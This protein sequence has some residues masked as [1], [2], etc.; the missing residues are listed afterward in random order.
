MPQVTKNKDGSLKFTDTR[1][2]EK[3]LLED[4]DKEFSSEHMIFS[5]RTAART[6]EGALSTDAKSKPK[7]SAES[8]QILDRANHLKQFRS[9]MQLRIDDGDSF[10]DLVKDLASD[11]I[12]RG[13]YEEIAE[14][15]AM[16]E[17]SGTN[18]SQVEAK[19]YTDQ[20]ST[21]KTLL[22]AS[23]NSGSQFHQEFD[24]IITS[25]VLDID[26]T[27]RLDEQTLLLS[28]LL[29]T[30]KFLK[31]YNVKVHVIDYIGPAGTTIHLPFIKNL[32]DSKIIDI[33]KTTM[34]NGGV[35]TGEININGDTVEFSARPINTLQELRDALMR[36]YVDSV[37]P[38]TRQSIV[39]SSRLNLGDRNA[40]SKR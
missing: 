29:A 40:E 23:E 8:K 30:E 27:N 25:K 38:S 7:P 39:D 35:I 36:K 1:G 20:D 14:F 32:S 5:D 3:S 15:F 18:A 22:K 24:S 4:E 26:R 17:E 10:A 31:D 37:R 19:Q 16:F 11:V 9:A 2:R 12:V 34:L 33:S 13:K 21:L 6:T 28:L